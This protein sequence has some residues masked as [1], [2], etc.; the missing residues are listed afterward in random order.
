MSIVDDY[1]AAFRRC[2]TAAMAALRGIDAVGPDGVAF[3]A[4]LAAGGELERVADGAWLPRGG[5]PRAMDVSLFVD[6]GG[7]VTLFEASRWRER[8]RGATR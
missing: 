4:R 5:V 1:F 8:S 3:N 6:D 7:G 2:D